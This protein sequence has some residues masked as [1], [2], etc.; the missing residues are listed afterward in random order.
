MKPSGFILFNSRKPSAVEG[1]GLTLF[2]PAVLE[3]LYLI[4]AIRFADPL[5]VV[6]AD[7]RAL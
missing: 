5:S 3:T 1:L 7:L 4:G 6:G 2:A